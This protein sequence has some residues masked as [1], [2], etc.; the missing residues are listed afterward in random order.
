METGA[1]KHNAGRQ[2]APPV[3]NDP[4][5]IGRIEALP[6]QQSVPFSSTIDLIQHNARLYPHDTALLFQVEADLQSQ[7]L[8]WNYETLADQVLRA[9][10]LLRNAGVTRDMPVAIIAPNIPSTHVALWGAQLA[11]CVFPINYLLGAEHIAGL[12]KAAEVKTVI[13]L[14]PTQALNIHQTAVEACRIAGGERQMFNID[15]NEASPAEGSFQALLRA[16]EPAPELVDEITPQTTA[17][18][19]HT[20]GTTGLPKILR[21]TH[22]NELHV[23]CTAAAYYRFAHGDR[24]LNGFPVFHVAGVFVYGLAALA[25]GGTVYIPTLLGMRNTEFVARAWQLFKA[26]DISHL[27][28]V[29]TTLAS[30]TQSHQRAHVEGGCGV[31]VALTGGS[32]LPAEIA[33]HF[34]SQTGVPVRNIFGMTE[35]AGIVAVEPVAMART[36]GSVGLALPYTEVRAIPLDEADN[37]RPE[38]FCEPGQEGI[39]CLRGPH[40]SPGYMDA[41]RNAGTFTKN[42]WL[43]SGDLGY[44]DADRKIF[45]TGRSKDLIIRSG[46]NID[47][48]AIE[49][50]FLANPKILDCAAVG[51]PDR[52]AG[53]LPVVYVTLKTSGASDAAELLADASPRIHERPAL[54]KQVHILDAMPTTPIG[55]IFKPALRRMAALDALRHALDQAGLLAGSTIEESG[56]ATAPHLVYVQDAG[57]VEQVKDALQGLPVK[58]LV[59]EK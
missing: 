28:C 34:E 1:V 58:Y 38:H 9:G 26:H 54:P 53:E 41:S 52:Y 55:K 44:V 4:D 7:P 57:Q 29:P 51:Q 46:H 35:C 42:G 10:T 43:I 59:L 11:G 25:V 18:I 24:M 5:S 16:T 8:A 17:A 56:D 19:F 36:P 23:S 27:G 48:Q 31:R 3:I 6:Y 49:E 12:L 45:I 15:P 22:G 47:P 30:L 39:L 21:H 33:S 2:W 40:V 14:G 37:L 32:A 20:G 13:T 50:A